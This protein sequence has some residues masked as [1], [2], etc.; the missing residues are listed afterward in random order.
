[1]CLVEWYLIIKFCFAYML[2]SIAT[3]SGITKPYLARYVKAHDM[4][5][6]AKGVYVAAD[7]WPDEL[8]IMH[9]R[10]SAVIFSGQTM[11]PI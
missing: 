4:E 3:D 1:M 10:N 7:V 11:Q 2:T 5:K 8:Y 6:V 9:I